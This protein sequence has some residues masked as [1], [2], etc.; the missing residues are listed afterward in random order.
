MKYK[1]LLLPLAAVS[2]T[3]G[4]AAAH[5]FWVLLLFLL[6]L[7]FIFVKTKHHAPVIVCLVSFCLYFFLYTVCDAANVTRYQAGS[8]TEQAV[9]TNIPKV[10]G[11]K[12]SAVIRTHDKEKWAAS[13]KIRSL[14]EKRLIEQLEPGMRCT[15]TGSLEQP[16]H[17][18]VPGGFDY[19]EYL[20]SQQIHWLFS[21]TSIQQCEKSKQPLFKLL[22]IRKNLIS[23]IR[24][25]VPESSAGIVEAL[26]LG[27]RFSIED[28]ILSAYQNLGVVHL[29]AISGMH[30][31]LITA[32]L[33][34]ALIR[35]GLTREKA[36]ILLL[37]FLPVYTLLSGAAPSVLRASLMLGFYIA[38]TLV[39]RG[40]HSSA[41]LSLSYL[42]LLLFNPYFLWQAGFQLSFA[43]SA[44]LI[45]SSSILKKAGKSRLAGLAMASFIA[46][47]SSLPFLL[48]HF[49]QISLVSFP[50]NMV[51][52]PFYTLFVIPV[53]VIGFL[54]L[55]LSGQMGEC[56]FDMFDLV[57]K[58]VHDFITYAASVDLF[59]MIVSKPDFL[60]LLLLAVSVF[61]LFAALEKG[62][63]LKLRKTALFFCA[64]LAYLICH[65]YFSPWGEADML[66]IGQGDSL[67][68]SAPHRKGTVMVD[69]GGVI[70]YPGESWKEKRHPYSIGEKVLIPF[71]N[72]KGVKKLDALIL[73]H[74]DQDHIGEAG[75]LIKN[76]RVKRLIVPVGFVKEPKDQ[77]ILNM[78]KENNIP[79]AEAKRGDTIT[80]GDLQFQVLSPE[81][82]DGRSKN[83]SSLVLWTVLS[84]VSWLLTGDLESDGETEVLKTYPNLKADILKAGHH[85]SKSSTSEAFLKQLQPEAALI[86]AGKENRYHHPHE[87]VLDR[88]KAY[89][90]NVLRTDIS[91][92]IQYRFKKGA[93]TFS[94]FPPYD[95]EETRAQEV[96]KTAD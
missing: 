66:D 24:N 60:S 43:V 92:T 31:G 25:H 87:E 71:L 49:Q 82:S 1:Y 16:A 59:T 22:N 44:S 6:Y 78:A 11:A 42:L 76:H 17:A 64:V 73:T 14:E 47:L 26:T 88:L 4:I 55:L 9:I 53:S 91:G 39:K 23:I 58:P 90:V 68:I 95:I 65:P 79:V 63:F 29:M 30:V 3:A 96:K 27:E 93:G 19:K 2:A 45:L 84:G 36:G 10:D 48:Y 38:G 94:V 28:D 12:M 61:T 86:S 70:A 50:M 57:M 54:L 85:G 80:A 20:Y 67:F 21:V 32:G 52:V 33:F 75:V 13:Y 74:A 77:T 62:G 35:I 69:T 15:F 37:L 46:E 41:A 89:S 56:L 83:D 81:S 34:Y 8:Y 40:I 72:G 5:V 7:L 18:T 51:M